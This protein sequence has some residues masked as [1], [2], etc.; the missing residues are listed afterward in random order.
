MCYSMTKLTEV[1]LENLTIGDRLDQT[2][3]NCLSLSLIKGME[4]WDTSNVTTM[5]RF[6]SGCYALTSVNFE[7]WNTSKLQKMDYAFNNCRIL[8]GINMASFDLSALTTVTN[9]F[10]GCEKLINLSFGYDLNIAFD[11]S[12]LY[13]RNLLSVDS[14]I[15][16]LNG[17]KDRTGLD[18]LT[19]KIGSTNL[20]KLTPEQVQIATDKN[21]SVI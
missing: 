4:S 7:N 15:S 8:A 16:I 19:A 17:L 6:L 1:N 11:D 10:A 9:C 14:L 21:W 2:F 12:Q 5:S 20:A 13:L 3:N 18:T